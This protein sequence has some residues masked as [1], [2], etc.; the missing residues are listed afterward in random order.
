MSPIILNV[1]GSSLFSWYVVGFRWVSCILC[2][3][4]W[5]IVFKCGPGQKVGPQ[6]CPGSEKVLP[7]KTEP[8]SQRVYA[9]K[10]SQG[11][12]ARFVTGSEN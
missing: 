7:R 12:K 11:G 3:S 4:G 10:C 8:T 9:W 5:G 1:G 2:P 6:G